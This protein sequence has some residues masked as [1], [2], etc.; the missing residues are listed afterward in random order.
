[1]KQTINFLIGVA[2]LL[3][4]FLILYANNTIKDNT[5]SRVIP[6]EV[7]NEIIN[8]NRIDLNVVE[9]TSTSYKYYYTEESKKYYVEETFEPDFSIIDSSIYEVIDEKLELVKTIHS[10]SDH[11]GME[12]IITYKNGVTETNYYEFNPTK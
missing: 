1:M 12:S 4:I 11:K 8:E 2:V 7:Y 9:K 6:E 10:T 3:G 5:N